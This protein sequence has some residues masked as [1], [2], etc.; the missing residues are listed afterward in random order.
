MSGI[1]EKAK[2]KLTDAATAVHDAVVGDKAKQSEQKPG[3]KKVVHQQTEEG[4]EAQEEVGEDEG[5]VEKGTEEDPEEKPK[6]ASE[7]EE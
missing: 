5:D 2:E 6:K 1:I 3:E 4:E 7:K